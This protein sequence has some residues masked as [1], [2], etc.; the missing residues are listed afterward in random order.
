MNRENIKAAAE[1]IRNTPPCAFNLAKWAE[2]DTESPCGSVACIAGTI[3]REHS[4]KDFREYMR[5]TGNWKKS[6]KEFASNYLGISYIKANRLF[7]PCL[8]PKYGYSDVTP[9]IAANA[10]DYFAETGE[11]N[12]NIAFADAEVDKQTD[13]DDEIPF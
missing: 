6:P 3:Q 8:P 10:L 11:I 7:V 5:G 1:L 13:L 12:W 9:E 2:H 4:P